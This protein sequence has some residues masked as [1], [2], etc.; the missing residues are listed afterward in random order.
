MPPS[1][2][3]V[4]CRPRVE[5]GGAGVRVLGWVFAAAMAFFLSAAKLRHV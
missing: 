5:G 4:E 3:S 2:M 1:I